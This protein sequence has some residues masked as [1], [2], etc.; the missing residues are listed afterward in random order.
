M[1]YYFALNSSSYNYAGST[2]TQY[3][4]LI[5]PFKYAT[6]YTFEVSFLLPN[7]AVTVEVYVSVTQPIVAR[8]ALLFTSNIYQIYAPEQLSPGSYIRNTSIIAFEPE[9]LSFYSSGFNVQLLNGNLA[10]VSDTFD[11]LFWFAK[12]KVNVLI[13]LRETVNLNYTNGP[14]RYD[15]MVNFFNKFSIF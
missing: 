10:N 13:K 11:V 6:Q 12:N 1:G 9:Q 15:L 7:D 3:I 2:C 8:R 5:R 4:Q 14:R